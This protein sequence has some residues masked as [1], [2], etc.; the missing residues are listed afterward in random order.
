MK[1][2]SSFF[3]KAYHPGLQA[4]IIFFAGIIVTLGAKLIQYMGILTVGERFPW[5][6]AASFLLF[7]ALFN[8]IFS[9]SAKDINRYWTKSMFSFA[10]LALI[11]G[12]CAWG[13]SQIGMNEA[14]SYRWIFIVV[15]FGYLVFLSMMGFMKRIVEFAEKEDWQSP[16]KRKK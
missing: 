16:R 4:A 3:Y 10:G 6:C 14:G 8:S 13:F 2:Q 1:N 7:F 5:M 12:L 15:T 11:S 9:L